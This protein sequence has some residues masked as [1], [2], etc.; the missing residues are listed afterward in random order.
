MRPVEPPYVPE[1]RWSALMARVRQR[2]T[3]PELSVRCCAHNLGFRFRLHRKDLPGTPD[4][5]FPKARKVIFVHGCFWHR[6][7][8]CKHTSFPKSRP[9]FWCEKFE[10]NKKRDSRINDALNE[11]GWRTLTVW[12]CQTRDP[13]L[14]EKLVTDFLVAAA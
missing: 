6:H 3:T 10:Q 12:E 2:D 13:A 14:L 9:D 8:G 5:V 7:A 4:I 1:R 11:L